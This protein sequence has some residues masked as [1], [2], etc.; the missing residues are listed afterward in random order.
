MSNK[1]E[2]IIEL[3]TDGE[4]EKSLNSLI[5]LLSKRSG[6]EDLLQDVQL[7]KGQ[8]ER[9]KSDFYVKGLITKNEFDTKLNIIAVSIKEVVK[10][11]SKISRNSKIYP[12]II[13]FFL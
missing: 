8:L 4:V 6:A 7:I 2:K 1:L 3:L 11:T 13:F 5:D 10:K 12:K 9:I